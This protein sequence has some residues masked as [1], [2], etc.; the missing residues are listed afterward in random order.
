MNEDIGSYLKIEANVAAAF[1]FFINGMIGALIY[2]QA[3]WVPVD[4]VSVAIDHTITC[5]LT[6]TLTALFCTASLKRTKTA[7]IL[8]Q[9]KQKIR[10]LSRLFKHPLLFGILLGLLSSAVLCT[11]IA[12]LFALLGLKAV[13]FGWYIAV[14]TTFCTL[15][16]YGATLTD[17][18]VGL[19]RP[20]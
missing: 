2:H 8:E 19:C 6:F 1:N 16:G 10:R 20:Q 12:P 7:G 17:L 4:P 13:P 11:L 14:K 9:G 3:D 15:L 18:Y 5:L